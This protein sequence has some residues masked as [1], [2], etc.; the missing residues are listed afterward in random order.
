MSGLAIGSQGAIGKRMNVNVLKNN[1]GHGRN[2]GARGRVSW[3]ADELIGIR[4]LEE[5]LS[6]K[7]SSG[8]LESATLQSGVG[9]NKRA[10]L[11][12]LRDLNTRVESLDR[13]LDEFGRSR[14][15]A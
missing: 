1:A 2:S 13:A 12:G 14:R 4:S 9:A 11:A 8:K 15:A 7:I 3:I 6:K 5:S 10:L